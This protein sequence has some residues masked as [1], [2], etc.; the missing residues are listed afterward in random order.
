LLRFHLPSAF[1]AFWLLSLAAGFNWQV[2]G[3]DA[4]IYYHGSAALLAGGDPWSI[5]VYLSGRLFSY[6]GL[7]PTAIL[8][9]PLTVLPEEAFVWLWLA[10]SLVA[11]VVVVRSLRLPL[12][13]MAYPPLLYGV[14]AANPHALLLACLVAGGTAGGAFASVLK[15]VA[16]PP[17]VGEGRWR[18]VLLAAALTGASVILA[19]GLWASFLQQAGN[20]SDK[21]HAESEGGV[22]A[23][24]SPLL[25]PTAVSLC[26][27]A[28]VD[29]RAAGWLVVPA[30]F[31]TTQYYYAI[32]A[33][34]VDPF[35][36]AGMAVPLRYVPAV[37]TIAYTAIRLGLALRERAA[38]APKVP[39]AP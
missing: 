18:A 9:A 23:W 4:R 11:A 33:L 21:I 29:R 6:A 22:S 25:I 24:G 27:L 13:W 36:A 32:F 3:L 17:L 34:P 5:G 20:V 28:L 39:N 14:L 12:I 8:L 16:I 30:V 26:V 37:L 19:P 15:V 2:V 10:L 31:P 7:P 1:V 38:L 35:L